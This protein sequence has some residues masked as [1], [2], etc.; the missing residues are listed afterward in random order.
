MRAH[1]FMVVT[2]FS[3]HCW[4]TW[5]VS[6]FLAGNG[7]VRK[8]SCSRRMR[9]RSS[10]FLAAQGFFFSRGSALGDTYVTKQQFG[11]R[12][13]WLPPLGGCWIIFVIVSLRF[14]VFLSHHVSPNLCLK[15]YLVTLLISALILAIPWCVYYLGCLVFLAPQ[16][17]FTLFKSS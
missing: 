5:A 4:S 16:D 17:V 15:S 1:V 7:V 11:M 12:P 13:S 9:A 8:S 2:L 10:A 14:H 6:L 3:L